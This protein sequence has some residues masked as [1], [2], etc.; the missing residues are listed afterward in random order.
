MNVLVIGQSNATRWFEE[1]SLGAKSF[2][3]VLMESLGESVTFVNAAVGATALLPV[4]ARN[5]SA[6]GDGSLYQDAID[7]ARASGKPIDAIVWIQGEDDANAGVTADAYRDA[8]ADLITRLRGDLGDVP[9]LIQRELIPVSGQDAINQAQSDYVAGDPDAII[10]G[11]TPPTEMLRGAEH[12]TGSGYSLLGDQAARAL[13]DAIGAPAPAPLDKGSA[14]ADV[15]DGSAR[16]DRMLGN[17]GNDVLRGAGGNDYLFGAGDN[18]RISGSTGSDMLSGGRGNDFLYGGAGRDF[19]FGDDG[20]DTL[21][22]GRG[23]DVFFVDGNDR[24][25]DYRT[26]E[27]IVVEGANGGSLVYRHGV[28]FC[29]GVAVAHLTGSPRLHF[30]DVIADG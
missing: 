29:D 13:I 3:G 10:F 27:D 20:R 7:A 14:A 28:L 8:L 24:I 25:T 4:H 2:R 9:V 21:S 16:A 26:G 17:S 30:S 6:T 22:G 23:R 18:D 1:Y 19:L 12:F 15:M 5:W 11:T